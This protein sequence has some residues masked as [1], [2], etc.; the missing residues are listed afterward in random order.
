MRLTE[1]R[2][3]K[4]V[5]EEMEKFIQEDEK[6]AQDVNVDKGEM[7]RVLNVPEDEEVST[8]YTSGEKLARDLIDKVGREEAA[9]M[10]NFAANVNDEDNIFDRAQ[11][12]LDRIDKGK[13]D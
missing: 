6:W 13:E 8:H 4:M 9:G 2:L 1:R 5:I 12:S 11:R 10:I 7:H 3:K